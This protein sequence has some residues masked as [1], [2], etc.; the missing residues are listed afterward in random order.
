[1]TFEF[2]QENGKVWT[3]LSQTTLP[4]LWK[5]HSCRSQNWQEVSRE[6]VSPFFSRLHVLEEMHGELAVRF[7]GY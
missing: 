6:T 3:F 1:M 2:E 7:V 5:K 4:E